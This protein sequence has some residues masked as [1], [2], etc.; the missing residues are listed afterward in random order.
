MLGVC[1]V[2]S[3]D[4]SAPMSLVQPKILK[5]H[6]ILVY[7]L[8]RGPNTKKSKLT[9]LIALFPHSE[10]FPYASTCIQSL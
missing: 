1:S 10:Q 5:L 9:V 7:Y 4:L 3:T 6:C 8:D 2:I